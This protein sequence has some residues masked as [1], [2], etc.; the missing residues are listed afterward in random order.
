MNKILKLKDIILPKKN[1]KCFHKKSYLGQTGSRVIYEKLI[2][3]NVDNAFI[4][5]GGAIMSLIDCFH[6]GNIN[7]FINTHEQ[8]GGH[9]AT[10]YA[11][12]TGKPGILITTSGPGLT[13]TITAAQ[14]ATSDST[15]LIILSGQVS[16]SAMGTNAFQ[17]VDAINI[18]KPVTKW[19]Y[20]INNV[21]EIPFIIDKAF[22]IA[23][24]GKPGAVHIDLPKC[25]LSE[26]ISEN[27]NKHFDMIYK[28]QYPNK[29]KYNK[30]IRLINNAKKP[31]I[32]VGQGCN[33]AYK[34]LRQLV[35][36]T[37][38][39]VTTTIHAM[40]VFD[41]CE[42]LSLQFLGM[43]GNVA[44]NYAIQESDL[45]IALGT[46]F[47]D[48]ITGNIKKYAP[49]AFQAYNKN[50]GGIIHVNINEE[51]IQSVIN[52]H[53][54]FNIKCKDFISNIINDVKTNNRSNWLNT[55]NNWKNIYPFKYNKLDYNLNTQTVISEINK[56]LLDKNIKDYYITSGVGNHQ[57]MA[58]Q[59]IKWKY[60]GS[61]I[62]SGGLGVMGVGLPYAIG[63]Q[64]GN[65]KSMIIDLDGDGSFNHT[66]AELKTVKEYN[67][68]IKIAVLNDGS[69][70]MVKAWEKLF[71][72]GR[73]TATDMKHNPNYEELAESFNIMSSKCDNIYDLEE[74]VDEFLTYPDAILCEF[75]VESD[76]CLPLVPPGSALNEIILD[77][78]NDVKLI[79]APN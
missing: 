17:E 60:P 1:F 55:I 20:C 10:G 43:H 36:K 44:A 30:V 16:K 50:E 51:E 66:L 56:Q 5:S 22:K 4:Y 58:S 9:S 53:F 8:S 15:P 39:P 21:N 48:R 49:K 45:I 47:D 65:P 32:L 24:Q 78:D 63:C 74:K 79:E 64:I 68:P 26:E 7:Y 14:D 52:T 62:S 57:M 3:N 33:T 35:R 29:D 38:I 13:N 11:K 2:E 12:S 18:S 59:F 69:M 54:N 34:E 67:L 72:N 42:P 25:I 46:R 41:E 71:F 6:N 76:L 31:V 27:C 61:F 28:Y 73:I 70:S 19:S 37:Q 40:G 23:T 75:K 77:I